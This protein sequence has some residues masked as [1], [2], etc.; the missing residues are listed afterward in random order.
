MATALKRVEYSNFPPRASAVSGARLIN[1]CPRAFFHDLLEPG[2][3]RLILVADKAAAGGIKQ[4]KNTLNLT[5][6]N[7]FSQLE[8]LAASVSQFAEEHKATPDQAYK[9]N[10]AL[11]EMVSNIIKYGF[12][13]SNVHDIPVSVS[14]DENTILL[15]IEDDGHAFNP[16]AAPTPDTAKPLAE[17]EV[18]GLGIHLVK[19]MCNDLRYSRTEGRNVLEVVIHRR[20]SNSP[21]AP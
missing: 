4:M 21:A 8:L 16:L 2:G 14:M 12:D 11:E 7:D 10:L 17:R 19:S 9:L 5:I 13:D 3:D 18:G 6:R 20:P 1:R 15:R